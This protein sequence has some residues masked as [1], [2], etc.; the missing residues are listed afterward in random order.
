MRPLNLHFTLPAGLYT[1]L[2]LLQQ[3]TTYLNC[4]ENDLWRDI[5]PDK[6]DRLPVAI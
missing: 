1:K 2:D 6:I 3:T 4:T 5:S